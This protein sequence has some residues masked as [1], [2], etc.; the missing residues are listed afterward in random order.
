MVKLMNSSISDKLIRMVLDRLNILADHP[1]VGEIRGKGLLLGIELVTDKDN[2]TPM[3]MPQANAIVQN[4]LKQGVSIMRNGFTIPGLGNIL[5]MC[6]PLIL[7]ESEADQIVDAVS[8]SL[9]Q[10]IN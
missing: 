9:K 4:C 5:I 10:A 8:N 3:E 1:Y 2:K 6:P 7:K